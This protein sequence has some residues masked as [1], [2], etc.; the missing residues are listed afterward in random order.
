MTL[1]GCNVYV[2]AGGLPRHASVLMD[3]LRQCQSQSKRMASECGEQCVL[4]HAFSDPVYNRSSFHLAGTEASIPPVVSQ[5]VQDAQRVLRGNASSSS[6]FTSS[7]SR[8]PFVGLVDHVSVM[9]LASSTSTITAST[10]IPFTSTPWGR[11]ARSIGES[12]SP[13]TGIQVLYYGDADPHQTSLALVR[14]QKTNFFQSGGL[15]ESTTPS[16]TRSTTTAKDICIVGA[17]S[18]FVENYN[19]RMKPGCPKKVAQSLT[20]FL[21]ERDGGLPGVEALTLPYSQS[22]FEV[23]CNL[24]KPKSASAQSVDDRVQLWTR[25]KG[26]ADMVETSYRVGTTAEQCLLTLKNAD[27]DPAFLNQHNQLTLDIFKLYVYA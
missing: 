3:L 16:T 12:L 20:K 6:S 19:I 27:Q 23:A 21:R 18:Q 14:R 2:S 11:A 25:T 10:A 13:G 15:Q 4:V 17:P 5:L 1:V 7:S 24:T 22:R 26:N 9:P 8:H